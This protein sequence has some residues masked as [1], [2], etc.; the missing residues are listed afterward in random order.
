MVCAENGTRYFKNGSIIFTGSDRIPCPLCGGNL[1]VRG[2]CSR[3]LRRKDGTKLYRLRV[4]ECDDCGKTHRELPPEAIPYKRL[5]TETVCEI[6]QTPEKQHLEHTETSTWRRICAWI[7]WFFQYA[8]KALE[9]VWNTD[10]A[11]SEQ[12]L[13]AL[14]RVTVNSGKWIQH[15]FV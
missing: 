1:H 14:V 8:Q 15:R 5:D 11:F 3:K 7:S 4:M 6:A 2:T 10:N 13:A 9:I 12:G